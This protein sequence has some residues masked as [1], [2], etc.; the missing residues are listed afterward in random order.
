[1]RKCKYARMK[2]EELVKIYLDL[3][4]NN[5]KKAY[6]RYLLF[7]GSSSFISG[8]EDFKKVSIKLKKQ[9]I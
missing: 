5:V 6:K 1:M 9:T 3:N 4:Q 2:C 8:L 7:D